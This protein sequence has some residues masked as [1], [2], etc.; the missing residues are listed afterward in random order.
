ML[1]AGQHAYRDIHDLTGVS[2]TT[3]GWVTRFLQQ[4]DFQGYK[5]VIDRMKKE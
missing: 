4:E 3:I 5:L 2:V 1:V